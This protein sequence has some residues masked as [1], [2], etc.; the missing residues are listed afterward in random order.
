MFSSD[1]Q[2]FKNLSKFT[3]GLKTKGEDSQL[4]ILKPNAQVALSYGHLDSETYESLEH[5]KIVHKCTNPEVE[6]AE[7][8]EFMS[9][10]FNIKQPKELITSL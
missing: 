1:W 6:E 10:I 5:G 3:I 4:Y 8:V 2:F 9:E 7:G